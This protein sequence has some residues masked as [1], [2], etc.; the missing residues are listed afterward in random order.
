MAWV[1]V[2]RL[3]KWEWFKVRRLRLPWILLGLAVLVSQLGIW[4]NY[5]AYHSDT[6]KEVVGGG[7]ASYSVSWDEGG[8]TSLTMTCE[9]VAND[10]IPSGFDE[11]SQRQQ[12]QFLDGVDAW[13]ANGD[14]DNIQ[15]LADYRRGFTVPDSITASI[16]DFASL[17]PVA[18]GPLLVM[19]LAASSMGT[20]YGW[21]TLRTVLGGGTGR[22]TLLSAK[23]LLLVL[24]CAQVLVVIAVVS[25][26]SSLAAAVV[27]P[28]ETGALVDPGSW[29]EVIS[30]FFKTA[31]GLLPIIALSVFA[32]VLTSSRGMGIAL[33]VGYVVAESIA[34][35]LLQLS[36]TLASVADYLLVEN[37]RSWTAV[38]VTGSS[39]DTL[40]GFL[41]ILAYTVL[42]FGAAS[43]IFQRRDI[44]GALGD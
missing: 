39:S 17:G 36:D 10:R 7:S 41:A 13:L 20:E 35:P 6:V 26:A 22:W 14:C 43:W 16:S 18:L 40:H 33:S 2:L 27:P 15:S 37:F 31:Y 30:M 23:L 1:H 5:L 12:E 34:V 38:Q 24:L 25:L 32:T 44:T 4:A 19:V 3:T 42:L 11:L 8:A 21:G 28:D 29:S 9:D